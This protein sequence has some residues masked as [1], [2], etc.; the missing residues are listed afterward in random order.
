[1]LG[2]GEF[3]ATASEALLSDDDVESVA[4]ELAVTG[5]APE[6]V[7]CHLLRILAELGVRRPQNN[8]QYQ[9]QVRRR[10]YRIICGLA[11]FT[12]LMLALGA[13][14]WLCALGALYRHGDG[15]CDAPLGKYIYIQLGIVAVFGS[16]RPQGSSTRWRLV[17]SFAA[18]VC[19]SLVVGIGLGWILSSQTCSQTNPALYYSVLHLLLYEGSGILFVTTLAVTAAI[20]LRA[21]GVNSVQSILTFRVTHGCG[22]AVKNMPVVPHDAPELMQ[23]DGPMECVICLDSLA[24][25]DRKDFELML[26]MLVSRTA[27]PSGV[28]IMST[29][30]SASATFATPE[31]PARVAQQ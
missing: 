26:M 18:S 4:E 30:P 12:G 10:V 1:M 22:Q 15:N 25:A 31:V 24:L 9:Q 6:R 23:E 28:A 7:F 14:L 3:P 5:P 20:V 8:E 21:A 16:V 11:Q 29:A 17:L 19:S 13:Y 27:S 2:D